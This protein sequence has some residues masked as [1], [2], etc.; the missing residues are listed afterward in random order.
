[1]SH[2]NGLPTPLHDRVF[3]LP[4]SHRQQSEGGI[5]LDA[6]R[7]SEEVTGVIAAVG[8]GQSCRKCGARQTS[9][10][11]IG[12]HVVFSYTN[13]QEITLNQETFFVLR[14]DDLLAILKE[15]R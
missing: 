14:F 10:V 4:D 2:N 1:M 5:W 13:G 15:E 12:D 6:C 8:P 11:R 7:N 9:P 3:V